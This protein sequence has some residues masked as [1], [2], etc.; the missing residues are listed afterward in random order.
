MNINLKPQALGTWMC[1]LSMPAFALFIVEVVFI[2][3]RIL[4]VILAS[5]SIILFGLGN[6][7]MFVPSV[8]N[9]SVRPAFA[10]IGIFVLIFF[11]VSVFYSMFNVIFG[12]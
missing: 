7:F 2:K 8:T 4:A 6:I 5:I 12:R 10:F 11:M 1:V 3:S 9:W